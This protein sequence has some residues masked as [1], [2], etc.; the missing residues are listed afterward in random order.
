MA[1]IDSHHCRSA[2][3]CRKSMYIKIIINEQYLSLKKIFL[4]WLKIDFFFQTKTSWV[5]FCYLPT[6]RVATHRFRIHP[7]ITIHQIKDDSREKFSF[8]QL[9]SSST[10]SIFIIPLKCSRMGEVNNCFK[11][12][13]RIIRMYSHCIWR[14]S[15]N[16]S[17][18]TRTP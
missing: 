4:K 14:R 17:F 2:P 9:L 16:Y 8:V 5:I 6:F 3:Y 18:P 11:L 15:I 10:A 13:M 7:I 1:S 12:Y